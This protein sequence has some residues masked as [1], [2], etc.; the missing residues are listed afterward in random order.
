MGRDIGR[1][2]LFARL[3]R[4]MFLLRG[5][6]FLNFTLIHLL[7]LQWGECFFGLFVK[8]ANDAD[9]AIF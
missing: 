8:I 7:M 1:G 6:P 9:N 3:A 5:A 2:S 4:L